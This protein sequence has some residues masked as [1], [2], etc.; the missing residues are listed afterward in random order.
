MNVE[1]LFEE[2]GLTTY[3]AKVLITLIKCGETKASDIAQLSGVPRAKVYSILDQLVNMGLIDKMP[4]RPIRFRAKPPKEIVKRLKYNIE[5]EYKKT[6]KKIREVSRDLIKV[7]DRLYKTSEIEFKGLIKVVRVGEASE[8]ETRIMFSEA[9]KEINIISKVF[10]YYPKIRNELI[11]AINRGV[12]IKILLL[13]KEFLDKK[14][15]NV[16]KEIIDLLRRDLE[17]P[18]IRFSKTNLP[19][20]GSIVDPSYDYSSG[21]AIFVVE[22]PRIPLY[23]RDAALTEN[24]SLVAGMKKYFDLIWK[25]E[26]YP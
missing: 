23:L 24:P 6:L 18:D 25:Y 14:G 8:R 11:S 20:R 9:K 5:T 22:D 19:L 17:K 15:R 4:E 13:G 10:E 3:Q 12:E 2:L 16:Q 7:L 21:K 1:E 26:S